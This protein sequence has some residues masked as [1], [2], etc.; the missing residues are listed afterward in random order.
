MTQR[1]TPQPAR[2][3]VASNLVDLTDVDFDRIRL[4]DGSALAH[5]VSR[6]VDEAGTPA[7]ISAGFGSKT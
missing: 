2:T 7:Q 4:T 3:T 5:A 6:V 1:E